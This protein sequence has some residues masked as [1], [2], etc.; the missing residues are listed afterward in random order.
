[1]TVTLTFDHK[2]VIIFFS[3]VQMDILAKFK[4]IP[5]KC[6]WDSLF[7]KIGETDNQN[8]QW[9]GPR[10]SLHGGLKNS[11]R[12]ITIWTHTHYTGE[13]MMKSNGHTLILVIEHSTR[14]LTV[15][16]IIHVPFLN[17]FFH[18]ILLWSQS[19]YFITAPVARNVLK[20]WHYTGD[21]N[22]QIV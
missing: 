3:L 15:N 16:S 2:I 12:L 8:T 1:M 7:T 5:W 14:L 13:S 22:T 11:L 19:N 9:I 21:Q 20:L 6:T 10:L 17:L 18:Y 4:D